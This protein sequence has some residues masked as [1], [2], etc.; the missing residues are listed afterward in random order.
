MSL[1]HINNLTN[2]LTIRRFTTSQIARIDAREMNQTLTQ[3]E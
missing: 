2:N 1:E 3:V